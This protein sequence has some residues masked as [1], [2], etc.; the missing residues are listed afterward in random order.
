MNLHVIACKFLNKL[1][2]LGGPSD[3]KGGVSGWYGA[4]LIRT[5]THPFAAIGTA[6][7]WSEK[8]GYL[9]II[10]SSVLTPPRLEAKA[11]HQL[12]ISL[13]SLKIMCVQT[14]GV[15]GVHVSWTWSC[16]V[17]SILPSMGNLRTQE[18]RWALQRLKS[19]RRIMLRQLVRAPIGTRR[20]ENSSSLTLML[21]MFTDLTWVLWRMNA[22]IYVSKIGLY[23]N[24]A[25]RGNRVYLGLVWG[26]TKWFGVLS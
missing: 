8:V 5:G 4:G 1:H 21:E 12:S 19:S 10:D 7:L 20:L 18:Q 17:V 11:M 24:P 25:Y 15:C 3:R 9:W 13:H 26:L 16:I 14:A 6:A 23:K 2:G 22:S